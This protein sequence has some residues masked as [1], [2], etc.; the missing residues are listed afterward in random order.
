MGLYSS[1]LNTLWFFTVFDSICRINAIETVAAGIAVLLF[2]CSNNKFLVFAT[3]LTILYM[4][5]NQ[6]LGQAALLMCS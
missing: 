4:Q 2:L 6:F 1:Q 3:E 5:F